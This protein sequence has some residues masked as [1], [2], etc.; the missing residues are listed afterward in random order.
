MLELI[1]KNALLKFLSLFLA[2]ILWFFVVSSKRTET[3]IEVPVRFINVS[4]SYEIV[5]ADDKIVSIRL[6]GQERLLRRL[7]GDDIKIVVN[8]RGYKAGRV[9]YHLS[10]EDI[11][12]P[13]YLKIKNISPSK[14]SFVLRRLK[15]SQQRGEVEP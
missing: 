2:T 12:L 8:L 4:P 6:E 5:D 7:K 10:E 11:S 9:S 13:R 3:V 15:D 1:K 14:I